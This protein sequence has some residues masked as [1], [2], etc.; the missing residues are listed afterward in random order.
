VGAKYVEAAVSEV[1][2]RDGKKEQW[3]N[4]NLAPLGDRQMKQAPG[5]T[6]QPAQ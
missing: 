1:R 5:A 4:D 2:F 3:L 6:T